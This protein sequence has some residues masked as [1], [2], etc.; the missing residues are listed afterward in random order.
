MLRATILTVI[1]S[2]VSTLAC[3]E[4]VEHLPDTGDHPGFV[5]EMDVRVERIDGVPVVFDHGQVRPEFSAASDSPTRRRKPLEAGW[6]FR[7]DPADEGQAAGWATAGFDD[8]D[9]TP[10]EVPHCW[11]MMPGGRFWDWG[12]RS[13]ANPPHYDGAAWYRLAFDHEPAPALRHRLEF[14]GVQQRARVFLN[15][16][17]IA[18]HE[19]EGQPLSVDVSAHLRRGRNVLAVKVIRLANHAALPVGEKDERQILQ[20]HTAHPKPPDNWPYAGLVRPVTLVA[21]PAV[22]ARKTLIRTADDAFEAAVVV[23][24]HGA[25]PVEVEVDVSSAALASAPRSQ[26]LA[27]PA[28]G[29]RVARFDADLRAEAEHWSPERPRLHEARVSVTTAGRLLD[30]SMVRFGIRTFGIDG[31]RFVLDRRPVFLN[32][33]A[34]YEETHERGAALLEADHVRLM[35]LARDA[36]V[37]FLRLQVGQR[38]PVA[39]RLAD[40]RGILVTGEWGGFWYDEPSMV[41][42]IA[43]PRSVYLSHGRCTI[44][45]LMNHPS[46]VLWCIHNE[47]H[48]FCAAYEPFVRAGMELVRELDWQGRPATWAAWHPT[49]G[50]PHFEHADAVGFNEYRGAMDPFENLEPDVEALIRDHPGK[51]LMVLE[52]GAWATRGRRSDGTKGGT[53][54]WQADLLVRQHEVLTRHVPPL[55]GFTYWILV[56]YRSRKPYTG[57]SR[58]DG[59]SMMG[60]YDHDGQPKLVRDVFRGLRWDPATR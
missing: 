40:E 14:L 54:D 42:Q 10:V 57:N 59:Y 13:T 48:Q 58:A 21:E 2:S 39:Y 1:A 24:N 31:P 15:G 60:M 3:G 47:S 11:D 50:E 30:E 19:A 37:N 35:D 28:G 17:E 9:W 51:P 26:R 53:E 25:A 32:G 22:T 6:R 16:V 8:A 46:V 29:V 56:D 23:C 52:N 45:D 4:I 5:H 20:V 44:W 36:G 43:D 34:V 55:A 41:A 49:K 27:L 38:S 12:D 18:R 33:V 7:F